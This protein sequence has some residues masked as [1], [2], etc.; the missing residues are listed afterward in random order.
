MISLNRKLASLA[1]VLATQYD[2]P[3]SPSGEIS[4]LIHQY[5]QTISQVEALARALEKRGSFWQRLGQTLLPWTRTAT[6][7]K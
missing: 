5:D 6:T 2:K 3:Y 4:T 1:D 7:P